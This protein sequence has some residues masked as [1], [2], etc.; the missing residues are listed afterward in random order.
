[1]RLIIFGSISLFKQSSRVEFIN[2][3]TKSI[4]DEKYKIV[5][6]N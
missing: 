3:L 4:E 1:M 2:F 5:I 6:T